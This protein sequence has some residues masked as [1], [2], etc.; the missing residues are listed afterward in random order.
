MK[1]IVVVRGGGD[2]A[3]GIIQ[4]LYRSGFKVIVLETES[5]TV[6][7]RTVS[8]AQAIFDGIT[9]V[10]DIKAVKARDIDDIYSIWNKGDIPIIIDE[11]CNILKEIKANVVVDA[12]IAKK[13]LGTHKDM[14][15][16]TIGVGPGFK[17]GHDV[18]VAIESN[19]GHDLGRLI[20]SGY[21]EEDTGIPGDIGGYSKERLIKSPG[22]GIIKNIS[23]IGDTV[24]KG[25]VIAKVGSLSVKTDIDGILR[26]LIMD[27]SYVRKGLKIGDV[28]PR[29]KKEHCYSI[30]DKARTIGG[31]VLEAILYLKRTNNVN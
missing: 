24:K 2:I 3:T 17:G 15:P 29:A 23:N 13:N 26:G 28:D 5:P 22:D 6:I 21:P 30:S 4:K 18:D 19:R 31:A 9:V 7:R 27:K 25:E 16:I 10:E 14:A 1:D 8:F 12:I 20:F 11:E